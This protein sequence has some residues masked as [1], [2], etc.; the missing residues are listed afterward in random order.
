MSYLSNHRLHFSLGYCEK[1]EVRGHKPIGHYG[2][3]FKSGSM[4]LGRDAM[5]FTKSSG[6]MSVGF[7]SQ[8]Y[9]EEIKSDTVLVPIVTWNATTSILSV[10]TSVR[11]CTSANSDVERDNKYPFCVNKCQTL[12]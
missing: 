6:T 7:L 12:Y 2:N 1:V 4:R 11:H 3:G 8:T 5:V 9:L 10:L